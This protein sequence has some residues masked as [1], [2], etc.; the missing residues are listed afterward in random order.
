MVER[1]LGEGPLVRRVLDP[2]RLGDDSQEPTQL[3]G[4]AAELVANLRQRAGRPARV[5][6]RV[7]DLAATLVPVG[8]DTGGCRALL[9][10]GELAGDV[11]GDLLPGDH[12]THQ[13]TTGPA[14]GLPDRQLEL[15][16]GEIEEGLERT[17]RF[18]LVIEEGQSI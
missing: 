5:D 13:L 2:A 16:I 10:H 14:V 18:A 12:V 17:P 7:D 15:L 1:L 11:E 3:A 9:V 4:D 6:L 8:I